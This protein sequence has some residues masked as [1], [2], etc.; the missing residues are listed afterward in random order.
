MKT[1]FLSIPISQYNMAENEQRMQEI[2]ENSLKYK[3][4]N[5][6]E[7]KY[8]YHSLTDNCIYF[9]ETTYE[10]IYNSK[11]SLNHQEYRIYIEEVIRKARITIPLLYGIMFYIKRFRQAVRKC[12]KFLLELNKGLTIKEPKDLKKIF[13]ISAVLSLKFF[14]DRVILNTEWTKFLGITVEELNL[15]EIQLLKLINYNLN[16]DFKN[17]Y[18]FINDYLSKFNSI[19]NINNNNKTTN[20]TLSLLPYA[21]KNISSLIKSLPNPEM[22]I[23]KSLSL[24][25][26]NT[27]FT[28]N[29]ENIKNSNEKE[30]N[31][32]ELLTPTSVEVEQNFCKEESNKKHPITSDI[33]L[34]VTPILFN[35]EK[36][37]T[38]SRKNIN[39]GCDNIK[40]D[41]SITP[42]SSNRMTNLLTPTSSIIE[43]FGSNNFLSINEIK[44]N[45]S[46]HKLLTP[47]KTTHPRQLNQWVKNVNSNDNQLKSL[48][49][50]KISFNEFGS[51]SY[52]NHHNPFLQENKNNSSALPSPINEDVQKQNHKV[53]TRKLNKYLY[54]NYKDHRFSPYNTNSTNVRLPI[55]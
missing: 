54:Q 35:H 38:K 37:P 22:V 15:C 11:A 36:L 32:G 5:K 23:E 50:N 41:I 43:S 44:R 31:H 16:L 42:N 49:S 1:K 33:S 34:S 51:S 8:L 45:G 6:N 9:L 4:F 26:I 48:Y 30:K 52:F 25:K 14:N 28:D 3:T 53:H 40:N 17:Y 2:I 24:L 21:N 19:N 20:G 46:F 13:I 29:N 27:T 55:C 12:P 10:S 7:V 18:I 39:T 47:T